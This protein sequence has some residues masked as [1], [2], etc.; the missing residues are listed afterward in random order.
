MLRLKLSPNM[1]KVVINDLVYL[2][3]IYTR[4]SETFK[5]IKIFTISLKKCGLIFHGS[6]SRYFET[7]DILSY[8]FLDNF[9]SKSEN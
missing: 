2:V 3:S 9:S 8:G 4:G 6:P 5:G 7:I 1:N